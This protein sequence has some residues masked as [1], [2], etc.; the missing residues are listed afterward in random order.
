[1]QRSATIWAP[2]SPSS[3]SNKRFIDGNEAPLLS[4]LSSSS[5]DA[6]LLAVVELINFVQFCNESDYP[7]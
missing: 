4:P 5:T 2:R 3:S 1:M 6:Y 7:L